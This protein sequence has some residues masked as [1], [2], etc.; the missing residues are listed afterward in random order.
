M[1]DSDSAKKA[2]FTLADKVRDFDAG[3][4]FRLR[5][6]GDAVGGKDAEA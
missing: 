5:L 3:G 1:I 4:A 6:L 2:L